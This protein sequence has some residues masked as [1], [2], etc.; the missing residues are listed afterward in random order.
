PE[1]EPR[2][3]VHAVTTWH[4]PHVPLAAVGDDR[5]GWILAR[6]RQGERAVLVIGHVTA[7]EL[8][9][10]VEAEA[11]T[12][13]RP[14]EVQRPARRIEFGRVR[15]IEVEHGVTD[16]LVAGFEAARAGRGRRLQG[17][18]VNRPGAGYWSAHERQ[19]RGGQ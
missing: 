7:G 3:L 17:R 4:R 1:V 10:G 9:I 19:A 6:G 15:P 12:E 5:H 16:D 18:G 8:A 14:R 2:F 11:I 13:I